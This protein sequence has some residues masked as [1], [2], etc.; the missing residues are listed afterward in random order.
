MTEYEALKVA[1]LKEELRDRGL[2][3]SGKKAELIARLQENDEQQV[4]P[5]GEQSCC[6]LL[7][8]PVDGEAVRSWSV[9]VRSS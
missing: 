9:A 6:S 3:V 2:A 5:S 4:Q 1:E 8:S 7:L